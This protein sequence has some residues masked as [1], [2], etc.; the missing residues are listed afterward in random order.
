M[1]SSPPVAPNVRVRPLWRR[2]VFASAAFGGAFAVVLSMIG[3]AA[4]W[5]YNHPRN[6][7]SWPEQNLPQ[8]GIR[9]LLKTKW[10]DGEMNYR[11][12]I[13]PAAPV[14]ID[15]F[16]RAVR[17]LAAAP[18][19]E[20][21]LYDSSGFELCSIPASDYQLDTDDR[22]KYEGLSFN[23][24]SGGCSYSHYS[25]AATWA[26]TWKNFPS[27]ADS[28]AVEIEASGPKPKS[29]KSK[30]EPWQEQDKWRQLRAGM[31]RPEVRT[32]LGEPI[33]IQTFGVA[34]DFWYYPD[35]LGGR[36]DFDRD[37]ILDSW[38]EPPQFPR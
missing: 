28:S 34:G 23:S 3:L 20:I 2:L 24:A 19:F 37:G 5:Y 25:D 33:K 36:L 30:L 32:L 21:Q 7:R 35:E 9:A 26:I 14:T 29:V 27:L 31:T 22:G 18:D 6:T 15:A 12:E 4:Y 1:A 13:T 10:R 17:S 8:L 38:N 16:D 11:L